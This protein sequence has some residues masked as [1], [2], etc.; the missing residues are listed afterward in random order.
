MTGRS[1]PAVVHYELTPGAVELREM[2]IPE[3][4]ANEVLLRVRG[5]GVCGS[6]VHQ[7]HNTQ[8]W[9]VRVPVIL[10][11]EF[12]G[13][14]A[15]LGP[16]VGGFS[17]GQ[18]VASETAARVD[19]DSPLT[20][21][22]QYN[23]DPAR[24]GFGYDIH[25]AMAEYVTVPARLLHHVPPN[26]PAEVAAMAEPCCVAYQA[27]VVNARIKPGDLVV[28]IGPGPIGLLCATLARLSGAGHV[29][30]VGTKRDEGRLRTALS[31]GATRVADVEA[32]DV[33]ALLA[34]L[35]DGLGADVIVDATG[36]SASLKAALEWVRPAGHISKVG[37]GPQ[38]LGFSMDPLVK[39]AVTLQGSFSH[40][41]P[42]WERVLDMLASGQLDPRPYL[43][44]VGS[45]QDWRAC[46]D[47]MHEG[48]L[49]KAVLAP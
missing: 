17:E 49:I 40:T 11:H 37:W 25:G 16:G 8:S 26:V 1:M 12:C 30:V 24:R 29:V 46:F 2:P 32:E 42:V 19:A 34:A 27:T 10:G 9:P 38:P 22:G 18:L 43:S 36:A 41:W 45:L 13:E 48:R 14:V 31:A 7:Y 4:T 3:P 47:G 5:V 35:G 39:K 33:S 15:A 20:R 6:D 23:L 28:V 44:R 21:V